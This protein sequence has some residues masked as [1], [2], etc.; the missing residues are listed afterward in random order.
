VSAAATAPAG[1]LTA[2]R[3]LA[4]AGAIYGG[5]LETEIHTVG[6]AFETGSFTNAENAMSTVDPTCTSLI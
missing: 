3:A 2:A 5:R 6:L 4:V 1:M